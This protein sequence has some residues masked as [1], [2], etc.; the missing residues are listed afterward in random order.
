MKIKYNRKRIIFKS[1][2]KETIIQ[3]YL[4][5]LRKQ[6]GINRLYLN[7]SSWS[8]YFNKT[9]NTLVPTES[10]LM[11]LERTIQFKIKYKWY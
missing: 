9:D 1:M 6:G 4:T 7:F 11:K 3:K 8:H 2:M 5:N 10:Y